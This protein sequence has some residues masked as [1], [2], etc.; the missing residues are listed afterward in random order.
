V[1]YDFETR[2]D[3]TLEGT[4]NVK[5]HIPTLCVAQ[6][7]CETCAEINDMSVRYRWCGVCK[8]TFRDDPVKQFVDFAT[9][10]TKCFHRIIC[11]AYNAKA[12]DAQFIL[13]YIVKKSKIT[14]QLR[15]ILNGTKIVVMTIGRTKFFDSVNYIPM[16]LSDLPEAFRLRDT[17]GK[18]IYLTR[19]KISRI[20]DHYPRRDII[21]PSK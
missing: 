14:E 8:F 5:I 15:L 6:Q 20:L 13:K 11:I 2:Q 19:E 21:L 7:I 18:G 3:E 16:R 12:F 9:R 1:F 17:S 10:T 4:E